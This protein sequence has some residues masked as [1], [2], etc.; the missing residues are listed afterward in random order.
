MTSFLFQ[1]FG[2]RDPT[3]G[4]IGS[5]FGDKVLGNF[6]TEHIIKPPEAIGEITGLKNKK[7]LPCEGGNVP[8][9]DDAEINR[10]RLQCAGWKVVTNSAGVQCI[11]YEWKVR[12]FMAGLELMK[13]LGE[14]AEKEG[15][16]PDLHLT[17]YNHVVAELTTHAVGGLTV[18][19]FIVASKV[20]EIEF[21]DLMPKRKPQ[22]WA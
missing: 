19:D 1:N 10:L 9:L 21:S 11:S 3:A 17:G 12:N 22:Y 6:D 16:H 20:N 13:R 5:N 4:E 18:N 14:L 15:H 8:K 2:A 7:C